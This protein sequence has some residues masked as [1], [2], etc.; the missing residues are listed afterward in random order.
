MA[1]NTSIKTE[2]KRLI[3]QLPETASW[4]DVMYEV[5]V[6][7]AIEQGRAD[8]E[9]GRVVPHDEVLAKVLGGRR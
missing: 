6:R 7:Q 3:D 1:P 9:A 2:A 8:I 5:Y 4:D